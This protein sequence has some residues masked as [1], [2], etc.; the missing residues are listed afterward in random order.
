VWCL[1]P[2]TTDGYW[3]RTPEPMMAAVLLY[4]LF[5]VVAPRLMENRPPMDLKPLI[6][7]YNFLLVAIS[8]YMCLEVSV[9]HVDRSSGN[10][11]SISVDF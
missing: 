3:L 2:R 7:V 8:G 1:D 11:Q 6:I 4:L 10:C 5:V 9:S